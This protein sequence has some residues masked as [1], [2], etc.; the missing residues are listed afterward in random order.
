MG[1]ISSSEIQRT[2]GFYTP[3]GDASE[4]SASE[5]SA[6]EESASEESAGKRNT[7]EAR[8]MAGL[9]IVVYLHFLASLIRLTDDR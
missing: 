2:F 1:V 5:E 6:S 3:V 4:E 8:N 9:L 7:A